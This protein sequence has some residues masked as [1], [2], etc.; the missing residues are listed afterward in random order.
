MI[1]NYETETRVTRLAR[2]SLGVFWGSLRVKTQQKVLTAESAKRLG[3]GSPV[4]GAWVM[5][6]IRQLW[7]RKLY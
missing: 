3:S 2:N 7:T 1:V 5:A 6:T 4:L